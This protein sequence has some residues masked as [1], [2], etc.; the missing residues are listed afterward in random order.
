[1]GGAEGLGQGRADALGDAD[2]L[3]LGVE[4]VLAQDDELVAAQAG[5]R[6]AGA[7][8]LAEPIGH[9]DDQLVAGRMAGHVVDGLEAVDVDEEDG[10]ADG[11]PGG[12]VDGLG[13]ALEEE[14]PVGQAGQRV[15]EGLVGEAGLLLG[16]LGL[17][18]L[19]AVVELLGHPHERAV[20][21]R[22]HR[23]LGQADGLAPDAEPLRLLADD[24]EVGVAPVEVELGEVAQA[25]GLVGR[26]PTGRRLGADLLG[27]RTLTRDQVVGD[28][29]AARHDEAQ[30]ILADALVLV[31]GLGLPRLPGL[32]DHLGDVGGARLE[33]SAEEDG[34]L[35]RGGAR[36]DRRA[37]TR[38]RLP[39][40]RARR[41]H[42][43]R[44]HRPG[45][46][47]ASTLR[48]TD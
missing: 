17:E 39:R 19:A 5:H 31:V 10:R 13:Q 23:R 29:R 25:D 1:M 45:G 43:W 28:L 27:G 48:R 42:R 35:R 44:R 16:Q 32:E 20:G 2:G 30:H 7:Q 47:S 40:R 11:A 9:T 37:P 21:S 6:V 36:L 15:V 38:A 22:A 4:Q 24:A 34:G 8:H 46:Q 18:L 14:D 33:C 41:G 12:G 3:A 26:G